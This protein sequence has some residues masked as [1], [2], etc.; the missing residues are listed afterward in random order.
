MNAVDVIRQGFDHLHEAVR[1]DVAEVEPDWWW[2]QPAPGVNHI[3]FL[4]W[5]LVRD[6]DAVVSWVTRHPQLWAADGWHAKLG[7]DPKEQGTGFEAGEAGTLRY[8]PALLQAYGDAVWERTGTLLARL[9][10]EDL[11]R[12]AW[13]DSPWN[14]GR[15]LV[16]GCLGHAW[17]HLGEIRLLM[18]LKGWRFRE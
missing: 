9:A 13:K 12:A 18:G 15:Q 17:L 2:W 6:E 7:L 10:E 5:H 14:I 8:D 3:G 1:A 11:D 16:E 4:Y